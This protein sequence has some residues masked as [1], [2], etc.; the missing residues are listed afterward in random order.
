[1]RRILVNK[2]RVS[3]WYLIDLEGAMY[4]HFL[5]KFTFK[6]HQQLPWWYLIDPEGA[7]YGHFLCKFTF[8]Y[9]HAG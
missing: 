3:W 2:W 5:C 4:G 7:I 6:Y 9:H 1:M 8:K